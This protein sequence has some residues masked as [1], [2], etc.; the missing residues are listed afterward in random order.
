[1]EVKPRH[2]YYMK[3]RMTHMHLSARLQGHVDGVG[4][5][6]V[7][8]AHRTGSLSCGKHLERESHVAE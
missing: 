1:M 7:L 3:Y 2:D 6:A 4:Y 8:R 5:D